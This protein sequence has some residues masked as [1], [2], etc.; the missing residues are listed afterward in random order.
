VA[1]Q[2]TRE[3]G[4]V[5]REDGIDQLGDAEPVISGRD[6]IDLLADGGKRIRDGDGAF[7][8][9]KKSMIVLRVAHAHGVV[10]REFQRGQRGLQARR[11]VYAGGQRHHGALVENHLQLQPQ[12][13]DALEHDVFV[14]LLRGDNHPAG[15]EVFHAALP[16][17]LQKARRRRVGENLLFASVGAVKQRAILRHDAIEDFRAPDDAQQILEPTA[18]DQNQFPPGFPQ[19][20][21]RPP[22]LGRDLAMMGDRSIVIGRQGQVPHGNASGAKGR[23]DAREPCPPRLGRIRAAQNNGNADA[24]GSDCDRQR[25]LRHVLGRHC[26]AA[27]RADA[28]CDGRQGTSIKQSQL[29]GSVFQSM[30]GRVQIYIMTPTAHPQEFALPEMV[31]RHGRNIGRGSGIEKR[32]GDFDCAGGKW[33][34]RQPQGSWFRHLIA[35]GEHLHHAMFLADQT[36]QRTKTFPRVGVG[37][38]PAD[39]PGENVLPSMSGFGKIIPRG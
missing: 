33:N 19:P 24:G 5:I 37:H 10:G 7:A 18:G 36:K 20:F 29:R 21:Q 32:P 27:R 2:S 35:P 30:P 23:Q 17:E 9:L 1:V 12:F 22:G 13:A 8:H 28:V 15:R 11:L 26:A 34:Q 3:I 16:H 31:T 6:Q 39:R 25:A 38:K 14:R 4:K